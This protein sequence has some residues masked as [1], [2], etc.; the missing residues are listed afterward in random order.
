MGKKWNGYDTIAP[1]FNGYEVASTYTSGGV[2]SFTDNGTTQVSKIFSP[3]IPS[4]SYV[5]RSVVADNIVNGVYTAPPQ[6]GFQF[7]VNTANSGF[8]NNKSFKFNLDQWSPGAYNCTVYW[9]DG[10]SNV[11]TTWNDANLTHAYTTS[12]IYTIEVKENVVGGFPAMRTNNSQDCT[13]I[14]EIVNWGQNKWLSLGG[15]FQGCQNMTITA[16]DT[17]NT[18]T[19][20]DFS[21]AF[22]YC[23]ILNLFPSLDTS[24]GINFDGA[25][26]EIKSAT[27][28]TFPLLNMSNGTSFVGCWRDCNKLTTMPLIDTSKATDLQYAWAGCSSLSSFPLINTGMCTKFGNAWYGGG[29]LGS[30][31]AP[32]FDMHS[33]TNGLNIDCFYQLTTSSYDAILNQLAYGNGGSIPAAT[34][35]GVSFGAKLSK[36]SGSGLAARNHLVNTRGWTITD[37]G[38]A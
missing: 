30:F 12:G 22:A 15:A 7:K 19:V 6:A 18:S 9:G 29:T 36:Y 11:I 32:T 31:N 27:A 17:P 10:T 23:Y 34:N 38:Q 1:T 26:R 28:T 2:I 37:G 20:T 4:I 14:T 8:T 13:K 16:T 5:E 35:N 25:F 21:N 3:T 33:M 24:S